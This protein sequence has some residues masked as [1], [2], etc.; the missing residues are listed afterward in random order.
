MTVNSFESSES[1]NV[2]FDNYDSNSANF[3][4]ALV[5]RVWIKFGKFAEKMK[6]VFATNVAVRVNEKYNMMIVFFRPVRV[7][8][9]VAR[10]VYHVLHTRGHKWRRRRRLYRAAGKGVRG[11]G[12]GGGGSADTGRLRGTVRWEGWRI[13]GRGRLVFPR[14]CGGGGGGG[15]TKRIDRA[16]RRTHARTAVRDS[17][18]TSG[19]AAAAWDGSPP[20]ACA[21][22]WR[23]ANG[24]GTRRGRVRGP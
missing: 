2:L 10:A 15:E 6:I 8:T 16:R 1:I 17:A 7:R 21:R 18:R 4:F 23:T 24:L 11:G 12:G 3:I 22:R 9:Y 5:L 14:R 20:P 13:R 19:R